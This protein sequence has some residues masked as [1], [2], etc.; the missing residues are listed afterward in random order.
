MA[1]QC[2]S[3]YLV[4]VAVISICCTWSLHIASFFWCHWKLNKNKSK[5]VDPSSQLGVSIIKPL[6]GVDPNLKANLQTY[7]TLDCSHYEILFCVQDETDPCLKIV[8]EL[9]QEYPKIDSRLFIGGKHVGVNPKINNMQPAYEA[10]NYPLVLI[11]DSGIQMRKDTL[12]NMLSYLT[13]RIALVH[14]I[15]FAVDRPGFAAIKEKIFFGSFHARPYLTADFLG[16][17]CVN[18]MSCLV[19]KNVLDDCGGIQAF[20]CYLAEDFFITKAIMERGWKISL[21]SL[22]ALQNSGLSQVPAFHDRII[23][24]T[25]LR[26]AMIPHTI[27]M[28]LISDCVVQGI[29]TAFTVQELFGINPGITCVVHFLVW[30][31]IDWLLLRSIQNG[32]LPFSVLTYV[33]AWSCQTASAPVLLIKAVVTGNTITWKNGNFRV[34]WGGKVEEISSKKVLIP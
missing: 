17:N 11:S 32:P 13:P 12:S 8:N 26:F 31:I 29:I 16:V 6:C 1:F 5:S 14:Q 3:D 18:G 19:R 4:A 33:L 9:R 22:P 27:L 25:K 24:W 10:V 28:E 20:G 23:R 34:R 2:I 7:F 15:P 21:C 30:S